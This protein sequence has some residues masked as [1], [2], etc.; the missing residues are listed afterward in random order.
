MHPAERR[1]FLL[2]DADGDAVGL[3]MFLALM[4]KQKY[5][6]DG[7]EGIAQSNCH[8]C[9]EQGDTNEAAAVVSSTTRFTW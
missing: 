8:A 9:K 2:S 3:R 7:E 4:N 1:H 6:D 5:T